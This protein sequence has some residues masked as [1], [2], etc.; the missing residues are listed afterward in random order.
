MTRAQVATH[1]ALSAIRHH[2]LIA[3]I[4]PAAGRDANPTAKPRPFSTRLDITSRLTMALILCFGLLVIPAQAQQTLPVPQLVP[5]F[6]HHPPDD[7][8]VFGSLLEA[9]GVSPPGGQNWVHVAAGNFC[10]GPEKELVLFRGRGGYATLRGPAPYTIAR[11]NLPFFTEELPRGV[12]AG[13]LDGGD[14]DEIVAIRGTTVSTTPD[15]VVAKASNPSCE[16]SNVVA[17]AT[18]TDNFSGSQWVD[19]AVGDF[20]GTG[21]KQIALLKSTSTPSN[22]YLVKLTPTEQLSVFHQS[23]LGSNPAQPWKALAAGDIDGDGVD[24]LIA[25][26]QVSD[27]RSPT[28]L[29]Y[30]WNGSGFNLFATATV[31]NDGNSDWSGAAVGDF[32]G[33]GRKAIVL[34][35]NQHSNFVVLDY[36]IGGTQLRVL[37]TADLDSVAGQ[38]WQGIAAT[39]WL[40]SDDGAAAELIAVRATNSDYRTNV[41]V[42]GDP[43]FRIDRDTAL[44][45]TKADLGGGP[46]WEHDGS[47]P[48][49][50]LMDRLTETHVNTI[51]WE[52][53]APGDYPKLVEFLASTQGFFV[54]GRQV[55]VWVSIP[56]PAYVCTSLPS[57]AAPNCTHPVSTKDPNFYCGLPEESPLTPWSE[58]AFFKQGLGIASCE[59]Y[60]GWA[61]LIGRLAQDYP[62][63]VVALYIDEL[64]RNMNIADSPLTNDYIAELQS[65]LRSRAP[66][67]NLVP[68]I[69]HHYFF[70]DPGHSDTYHLPD[71]AL[72]FDSMLFWFRNEKQGAGPCSA[73]SCPWGPEPDDKNG[74][75]LA[76]NCAEATVMNAPGEFA[77]MIALLPKGRKLQGGVYFGGHSTYGEPSSRYD[78]DLTKLMLNSPSL[79]GATAYVPPD[80]DKVDCTQPSPPTCSLVPSFLCAKYC[81]LIQA[82]GSNP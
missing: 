57:R 45:G 61:S 42:Y 81:A 76:G 41:F 69:Y 8:V 46:G 54:D 19:V 11:G 25:V 31:G 52:L 74:G 26:R 73:P 34:V 50:G 1:L 37:A 39:D 38:D 53:G 62:E 14:Y 70:I 36:P 4:D 13:N 10:G 51:N 17:S 65:M 33:D 75:C 71:L 64:P 66:W 43:F 32:N 21:K 29:A 2:P 9:A 48:I 49:R 35:K 28:V 7:S 68:G 23:D 24:E 40:G 27:G 6:V 72:T 79:G 78:H 67:L 18:I 22:V 5:L 58:A 63:Q 20:D 56:A 30:K 55:R 80:P 12:A 77:D 60:V 82:F 3:A 59:D 44:D 47:L 16:V 15:L